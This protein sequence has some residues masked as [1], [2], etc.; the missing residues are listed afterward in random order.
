[1]EGSWRSIWESKASESDFSASGRSSADARQLFALLTDACA[2][3][4]PKATDILL[5]LGCGVGLLARHLTSHVGMVVGLDFAPPLLSRARLSAPAGRF[6]SGTA[7]ALP[8]RA[9][10]FSKLLASSVLQYLDGDDLVEVALREMRRVVAPDGCAFVSGNP[11]L[12][13]KA[14]Y[15]AGIDNLDLPEERK[16]VLRERSQKAFWLSPETA[17][18]MAGR[19]GWTTEIRPISPAVWQSFYM[20]DLLLTAR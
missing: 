17:V 9:S 12:R 14:E 15:L 7:V 19:N 4:S 16:V 11:D 1:M 20:F 10:S 3:L 18:A 13:R 2:A 5:D 8:F 6:V